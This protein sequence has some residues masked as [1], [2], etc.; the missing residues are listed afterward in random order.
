MTL[1]R[2]WR[3]PSLKETL[4]KLWDISRPGRKDSMNFSKHFISRLERSV[5]YSKNEGGNLYFFYLASE[6]N[7]FVRAPFGKST[8][9]L[10]ILVLASPA[11][12][13]GLIRTIK[14]LNSIHLLWLWTSH[15]LIRSH[16]IFLSLHTTIVSDKAVLPFLLNTSEN[17]NWFQLSLSV[18]NSFLL[19][20]L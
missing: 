2:P 18:M 4:H 15:N 13:K 17:Y 9:L 8:L 12:W 11:F 16:C 6:A 19:Y 14:F 1:Q 7:L 20:F 5:F 10:K 3:E